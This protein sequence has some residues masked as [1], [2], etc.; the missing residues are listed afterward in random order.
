[1]RGTLALDSLEHARY[2]PGHDQVRKYD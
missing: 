2:D 1:L